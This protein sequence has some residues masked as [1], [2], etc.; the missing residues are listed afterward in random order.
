MD[1]PHLAGALA[2][3]KPFCVS[4]CMT[5]RLVT[6]EADDC[7]TVLHITVKDFSCRMSSRLVTNEA[8]DYVIH[9]VNQAGDQ[10]S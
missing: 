3:G 10:Q 8:Y 2:A 9:T 5:S 4:C 1:M 7:V 6:S